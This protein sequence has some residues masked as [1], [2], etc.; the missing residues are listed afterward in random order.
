MG[1][2][3]TYVHVSPHTFRI[4]Q[5]H[6]DHVFNSWLDVRVTAHDDVDWD[7]VQPVID[8]ADIVRG[9]VPEGID[10]LPDNPQIEPLG[11][12]IVN[13]PEQPRVNI[14]F[15][16]PHGR[17]VNEHVAGHKYQSLLLC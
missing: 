9:K 10:V 14:L 7:C 3:P 6:K 1:I 12:D 8:D 13:L 4:V 16:F 5:R 15:D 11:I 2:K 17:V